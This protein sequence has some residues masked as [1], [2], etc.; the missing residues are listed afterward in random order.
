MSV[1][2][3]I[4]HIPYG[5][6]ES[7]SPWEVQQVLRIIYKISGSRKTTLDLVRSTETAGSLAPP[8][9]HRKWRK[10][11]I[12]TCKH[13]LKFSN[14][15]L[16]RVPKNNNHYEQPIALSVIIQQKTP[17]RINMVSFNVGA[18]STR[19]WR[20][21]LINESTLQQDGCVLYYNKRHDL[22]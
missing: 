21:L 1:V 12:N 7:G 20:P 8:P 6:L 19:W 15:I 3:F 10:A 11:C 14:C 5:K 4:M 9:G 2:L 22:Y 18:K 16:L 17:L 13:I